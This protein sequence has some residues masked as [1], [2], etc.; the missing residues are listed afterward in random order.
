MTP[1]QKLQLLAQRFGIH[2]LAQDFLPTSPGLGRDSLLMDA[3]L[4]IQ[5]ALVTENNAGVPAFLANFTDPEFVEVLTAP[6]EAAAIFGEAKKGDWT[7]MSSMFP[8]VENTGQVSS[9]GDY[10]KNGM[11]GANVNWE[12]RQSYFYQIITQW[13]EKELAMAGLG[14][15]DWAARLNISAALIMNKYQNASYFFGVAGLDNYGALNDPSLPPAITAA[16]SW[17]GATA[18]QVLTTIAA[19]Y[20]Q[21][22]VQMGGNL[23]LNSKMILAMS[24]LAEADGLTK[25]S[26]FNVSVA[27]QLKKLYPAMEI[28]TAPEYSTAA[29]ELVQLI[30]PEVEGQKTIYC[31]FPEKMRAHAIVRDTSSFLQKKSGGTWGA[32]LRQPFAIGSMLGV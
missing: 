2:T 1:K 6:M 13:G 23:K 28:K 25:V 31:S 5:Q 19:L 4:P 9:Y 8:L 18:D 30:V 24:P 14:K 12:P 20:K 11:I 21:T 17:A 10:N 27:D 15:I 7:T 26:G 32:I 22:Q 3:A 29:G 16:Y